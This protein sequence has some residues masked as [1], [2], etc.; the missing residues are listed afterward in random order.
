MVLHY[1]HE[2]TT[3]LLLFSIAI[4]ITA[5]YA[6]DQLNSDGIRLKTIHA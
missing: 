5:N 1:M 3:S 2:P 6:T 4:L